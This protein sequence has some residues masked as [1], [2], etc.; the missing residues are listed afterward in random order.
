MSIEKLEVF[1]SQADKNTD[2]I[3]LKYGF[4]SA[5]KPA[6]QWFNWLFYT[7]T[8]KINEVAD[9]AN[10]NFTRVKDIDLKYE[11]LKRDTT[12]QLQDTA[13]SLQD[14]RDYADQ[15]MQTAV[16]GK[17]A[18]KTYAEMIADKSNI[19]AKS[20]IDV[21]ADTE[22][23]NGTYLYDGA[24]F[25]KSQ[26]DIEKIIRAK[27]QNTFGTYAQ[28]VASNL[29]DGAYALVADDADDKNGIYLKT[30]GVW[31]NSKYGNDYIAYKGAINGDDINLSTVV[32]S[33]VYVRSSS[34]F[35]NGHEAQ[36]F[37]QASAGILTVYKSPSSG[38]V[39]Q[40][41]QS[42]FGVFSRVGTTSS[43]GEWVDLTSVKYDPQQH[44]NQYNMVNKLEKTTDYN[45]LTR[46]GVYIKNSSGTPPNAPPTILGG[47]LK[48][49]SGNFTSYM[50]QE[51][52]A[53]DGAVYVRAGTASSLSDWQLK[54]GSDVP[55][56]SE[57]GL[58]YSKTADALT[59]TKSSATGKRLRTLFDRG[60]ST[61]SNQDCWG[62]RNCYPDD[63]SGIDVI[64]SGG[65]WETAIKDTENAEDHSGGSHGDEV[66]QDAYFFVDGVY[67][68]QDFIGSGYADKIE[69]YQKSTI[70]VEDSLTV[71]CNKVVRWT[72]TEQ[73]F[74]FKQ[75]LTF[76]AERSLNS[77][78]IAMLP[79]LRKTNQD[80]TGLQ[81][82]DTEVRSQDGVVINAGEPSFPRRNLSISNGDSITLSSST[83]GISARITVNEIDTTDTPEAFVQN[84]NTY[85]KIY[86]SGKPVEG[87]SVVPADSRWFIHATFDV[88][89]I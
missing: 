79:V 47:V 28:M 85:N 55:P 9:L 57:S 74:D 25:V 64:M 51:F 6:R 84:S 23:K 53:N 67:K 50:V 12:K 62:V 80:N 36:G 10:S 43:L 68:P 37:P 32:E 11:Q 16:G 59:F 82:T 56:I 63:V 27:V 33:G 65:V 77:A 17:L 72:F 48:V 18:Y 20:S 83:S 87:V 88:T 15:L 39:S 76:P 54:S 73:G 4:P 19:A 45:T 5:E 60:V 75:W 40:L 69:F 78:W 38:I 34:S 14:V 24:N 21:I 81:V 70:Y 86:I 66:L 61:N 42:Y 89:S 8:S 71:I 49:Y 52:L 7:Q 30:G 1:A 13:S 31:V 46:A 58:S 29:S 35:A 26:Y 22:D 2:G 3:T 44:P 41:Y